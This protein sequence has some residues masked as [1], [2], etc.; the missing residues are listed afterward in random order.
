MVLVGITA[1][2]IALGEVRSVFTFVLDYGWAGLGAGLGPA[3][4]MT[5]LWQRTT[6][7]GILA[8]MIVGVTT[9]VVWKQIEW[10]SSAFYSMIPAFTASLLTI[11]VI[12]LLTRL[13]YRTDR[14]LN[15]TSIL[16][17]EDPCRLL[18]LKNG[19]AVLR[20]NAQ[21][22]LDLIRNRSESQYS[23][24]CRSMGENQS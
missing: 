4:I 17:R 1:T 15:L 11:V 19:N 24:N 12:S 5:L 8:G 13:D 6:G 9:A 14:G 10:L 20:F 23:Q 21:D 16:I 7:P 22:P 2:A 18:F 3:L